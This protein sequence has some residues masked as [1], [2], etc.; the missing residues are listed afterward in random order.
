[1]LLAGALVVRGLWHDGAFHRDQ[2]LVDL[3]ILA[4][5]PLT[6]WLFQRRRRPS[7]Q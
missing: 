3:A 2:A 5:G 6:F 1:V 4:S 7:D